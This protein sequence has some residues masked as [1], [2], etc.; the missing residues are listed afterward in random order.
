VLV[1]VFGSSATP[2]WLTTPASEQEI[3]F[4]GRLGLLGALYV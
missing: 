1:A 3:S 2:G 4:T